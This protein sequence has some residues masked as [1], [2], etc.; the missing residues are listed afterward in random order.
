[1]PHISLLRCIAMIGAPLSYWYWA[2]LDRW[3]DETSAIV[4][5]LMCFQAVP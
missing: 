1:M 5:A 2:H 4:G 3:Q